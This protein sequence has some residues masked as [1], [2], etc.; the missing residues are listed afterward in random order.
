M[1]RRFQPVKADHAVK[2]QLGCPILVLRAVHRRVEL[3]NFPAQAGAAKDPMGEAIRVLHE[4]GRADREY[5]AQMA[6]AIVSLID[7]V[8]DE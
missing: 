5:I 1:M 6:A 4:Q 3:P 8:R 7:R 2:A